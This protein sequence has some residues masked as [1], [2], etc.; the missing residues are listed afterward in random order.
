M[1]SL[2]GGPFGQTLE[3]TLAAIASVALVTPLALGT[4][5][6][7]LQPHCCGSSADVV[8]VVDA[9]DKITDSIFEVES[10][11]TS[12]VVNPAAATPSDPV[13]VMQSNPVLIPPVQLVV[14]PIQPAAQT[15]QVTCP[16]GL[17][18]GQPLNVEGLGGQTLTVTVP[19]GVTPG[20][21][22]NI[23]VPASIAVVSNPVAAMPTVTTTTESVLLIVA[24]ATVRSEARVSSMQVG[25][26][27]A[28]DTVNKFEECQQDGH[29]RV[30]VGPLGQDA[31]AAPQWISRVT[32]AGKTIAVEPATVGMQMIIRAHA[33]VRSGVAVASSKVGDHYPNETVTVFEERLADGHV[34][35]K[36]GEG[37]WI[38]RITPAGNVLAEQI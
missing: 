38:S 26:L 29:V 18:A 23:Q 25:D 8:D 32:N 37:R 27:N 24:H 6:M 4:Y 13:V 20:Q 21:V 5:L 9:T 14:L 31:G 10:E 33:T 28:G 16:P 17:M 3:L 36:I 7:I 22:F 1:L 35:L 19:P 11:K 12:T 34:R 2:T 30:R 15:M